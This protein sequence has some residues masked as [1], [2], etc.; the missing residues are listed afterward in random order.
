MDIN[1]KLQEYESFIENKLKPDLRDIELLLNSKATQCEEWNELKTMVSAIKD[2][3]TKDRDMQI[4]FELGNGVVAFG[5]IGDYEAT[6]VD[7][8]LGCLLEMHPDEAEKYAD[9]RLR[10]LQKEILHLRQ[11]AVGV[12][13]HI[14]TGL[15]AIGE[16]QATL[17]R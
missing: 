11:L 10:L 12:K 13:M 17:N 15:L 3:K 14:K 4:Q 16:L 5:S 7:V 1:A 2:H 6:Y 8:G 9:I